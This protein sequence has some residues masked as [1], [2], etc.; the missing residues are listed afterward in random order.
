MLRFFSMT[1]LALGIGLSLILPLTSCASGK[2]IRTL[3]EAR[4]GYLRNDYKRLDPLLDATSQIN[5]DI[6]AAAISSLT[7]YLDDL[8]EYDFKRGK[9][10]RETVE[11]LIKLI[12]R[13]FRN[14]YALSTDFN[15]KNLCLES[16]ARIPS[17]ET[18]DFLTQVLSE[19]EE[20]SK[21][22]ALKH[23][24]PFLSDA[25]YK[26]ENSLA[27]TLDVFSKSDLPVFQT[28]LSNLLLYP[29]N[30]RTYTALKNSLGLT[31]DPIR[32]AL[33]DPCLSGYPSF[34]KT[35]PIPPTTPVKKTNR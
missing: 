35:A 2:V 23:L 27:P 22:L 33:L 15:I 12:T 24:R 31:Q 19:S 5:R 1:L 32:K 29:P 18:A 4:Q 20:T 13:Q 25:K 30:E 11:D 7:S 26:T 16:L 9:M 34:S 3:K 17:Q 6:Q 10:P 21:E 14:L 28:A 8:L